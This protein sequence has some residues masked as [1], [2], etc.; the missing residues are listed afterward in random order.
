L[1]NDPKHNCKLRLTIHSLS[2]SM[3]DIDKNN[4]NGLLRLRNNAIEVIRLWNSGENIG[5][6]SWGKEQIVKEWIKEMEVRNQN[7][8]HKK[9]WMKWG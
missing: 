7:G 9:R 4:C 1:A 2:N 6:I 8:K 3:S 5:F